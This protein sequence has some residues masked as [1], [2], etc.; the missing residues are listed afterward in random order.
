[1]LTTMKIE[2]VLLVVASAC[3]S[4]L[5]KPLHAGLDYKRY[6]E[7]QEEIR[8]EV[9]EYLKSKSGEEAV[10]LGIWK[11]QQ[12]S[13]STEVEPT[14]DE[15]Q[16][17]FM[18]K[19]LVN[20]LSKQH[21]EATFSTDSPFT[22][23]TTDEFQKYV[24]LASEGDDAETLMLGMHTPA[25]DSTPSETPA[26]EVARRLR[27]SDVKVESTT[28]T[29]KNMNDGGNGKVH[30]S[31][32]YDR[33]NSWSGWWPSSRHKSQNGQRNR[34]WGW[35]SG[36]GGWPW[37][38]PSNQP[39]PAPG[40]APG[41]QPWPAPQ[42]WPRP[43]PRPGPVAPTYAP[44][45]PRPGPQPGPQP[46]P[47][48]PTD[49]P[50]PPRPGP[51]PGPVGPVAP[52]D[53]PGPEPNPAPYPY[54][55]DGS[56]GGVDWYAKGCVTPVRNQGQCG[57]CWA[58]A[59]VAAIE[60]ALCIKNGNSGLKHLSD[61]MLTSC[62]TRNSGCNGGIPS[63]A[64][65]WVKQNGGLCTKDSYPYTSADRGQCRQG[66]EK[67]SFQ[68]SG[69]VRV[70]GDESQLAQAVQKQPVVV[71][72]AAGNNAWKQY[73]GGVLSSCDTNRPDHAVLAYGY[74]QDAWLVKNSWGT[75]WGESGM[76][77][78][79]RGTGGQGICG[80]MSQASYPG[81]A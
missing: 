15:M 77:R 69:A 18:A 28:S 60:S 8:N 62:D 48:A 5:A 64:I 80:I 35:N 3:V 70:Q 47:V 58:F 55:P 54:N 45:P 26:G 66:C 51:R 43:A 23:L 76:I 41:P 38:S 14:E 22:L 16:R 71:A 2:A 42:P 11:H 30:P 31:N 61:Q 33:S 39:Y 29:W 68:L 72:V 75:S 21:P 81:V 56:S 49:A 1:M 73:R 6:L 52:T 7:S 57:S 17:F 65:E 40:P 27:D 79:R 37:Y 25:N 34:G 13:R 53:A 59:A 10:R 74:T 19:Q 78:L 44:S 63:Y 32:L 67:V 50:S 9:T 20:E 4:T 46:G 24:G 12:E 36:G